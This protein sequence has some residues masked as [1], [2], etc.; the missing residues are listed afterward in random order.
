[1]PDA[2]RRHELN[3]NTEA[4]DSSSELTAKMAVARHL[5]QAIERYGVKKLVIG[6]SGGADRYC[7]GQH[8]RTYLM[9]SKH[10]MAIAAGVQRIHKKLQFDILAVIV[11]HKLRI[12]STDEAH[13]VRSSFLTLLLR[14]TLPLERSSRFMG[15]TIVTGC[16]SATRHGYKIDYSYLAMVSQFNQPWHP[17]TSS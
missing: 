13:T 10:S 8:N 4:A 2:R 16:S 5:A 12:E 9:F 1:M 3:A 15:L 14:N 7:M 6:V 17:G 11:D